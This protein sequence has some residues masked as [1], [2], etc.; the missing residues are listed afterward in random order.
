MKKVYQC[1]QSKFTAA[2]LSYNNLSIDESKLIFNTLEKMKLGKQEP[3]LAKNKLTVNYFVRLK[4]SEIEN[5]QELGATLIEMG[6]C[7][8]LY[9]FDFLQK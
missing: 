5:S 9:S 6:K 4:A 2:E 1:E 8:K 7:S 3:G